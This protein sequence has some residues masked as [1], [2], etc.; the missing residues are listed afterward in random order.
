MRMPAR[1]RWSGA[2]AERRVEGAES[3][4]GGDV[5][6]LV[7][8]PVGRQIHL[9]VHV[10]HLAAAD[11]ERGVVEAMP[12]ALED[13]PGDDVDATVAGR[14]AEGAD[15]GGVDRQRDVGHL[16]LEEVP[17]ERELGEDDQAGALGGRARR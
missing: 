16:V 10:H 9:A 15:L 2:A 3:I 8:E 17:G 7:E 13:Q 11:V 14:V 4:T 1:Q 6:L 12:V 5:A